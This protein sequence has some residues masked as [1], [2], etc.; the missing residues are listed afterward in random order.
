MA[1]NIRKAPVQVNRWSGFGRLMEFQLQ[2]DAADGADVVGHVVA[3]L[4][5]AAGGGVGEFSIPIEEGH[6]DPVDLGLD[7]DRHVVALEVF[8]QAAV[9]IDEL[10]LG[11]GGAGFFDR[12]GAELEDVVD[13]EHGDGVADLLEACDGCAAD[14]LGDGVRGAEFGVTCFEGFEF[15]VEAVELGVGDFGISLV[16]KLVVALEGGL[17]LAH[18]VLRVGGDGEKIRFGHGRSFDLAEKVSRSGFARMAEIKGDFK[19]SAIIGLL[20]G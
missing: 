4:A 5:V 1:G 13:A 20:A 18:P 11:A 15:A 17:Q 6:G 8:L 19:N 7:G 16:V 10:L 14:A 2:R 9:E 12:L 3:G